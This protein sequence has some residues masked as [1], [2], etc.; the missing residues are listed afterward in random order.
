MRGKGRKGFPFT[1]DLSFTMEKLLMFAGDGVAFLATPVL[2][3]RSV[4]V[5]TA[6]EEWGMI[7]G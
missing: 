2:I 1:C 3:V 5:L 7:R 4:L 6:L